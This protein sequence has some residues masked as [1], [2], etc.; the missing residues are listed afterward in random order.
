MNEIA[1]GIIASGVMI[2]T[3]VGAFFF[4]KGMKDLP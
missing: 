3:L 2:I 4:R 1:F